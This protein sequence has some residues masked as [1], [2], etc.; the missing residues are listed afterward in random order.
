MNVRLKVNIKMNVRV[1]LGLVGLF[2]KH[3]TQKFQNN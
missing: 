2:T 1:V 3:I